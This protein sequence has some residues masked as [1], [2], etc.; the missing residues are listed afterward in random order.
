RSNN[1]MNNL[2][3]GTGIATIFLDLQLRILRFT[4]ASSKIMNIM[5]SDIGR[6]V[7]HF[8]LNLVGY[9]NFL[10]DTQAVMSTL[11]PIERD[12]RSIDSKCYTMRIQPYRTIDNIIEGLVITFVDITDFAKSREELRRLAL[13][14]RD[15]S[16]AI[17]SQ[18]LDGNILAWN[19]AAAKLY[20]W[21]EK[22]ALRMKINKIIPD[23][24]REKELSITQRLS[25]AEVLTPYQTERLCQDGTMIAVTKTPTALVN[26]KGVMYAIS[27]IERALTN[28]NA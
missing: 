11:S 7:S 18:D 4:S 26:E 28:T 21:S 25:I 19:P 17:I 3:A 8:A 23:H 27:S 6:P 9:D 10:E 14:I 24:L 16:D 15:A 12:V 20:G 2:L 13:I 1:D 5:S 22:E